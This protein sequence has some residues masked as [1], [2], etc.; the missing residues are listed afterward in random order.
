M[1]NSN[2]IKT[3]V[4]DLAEEFSKDFSTAIPFKLLPNG[5]LLYKNYLV[6]HTD[7][8]YWGIF[9]VTDQ[10]LVH[11]FF[12]KTCALLA[13]K[14]YN[15]LKFNQYFHIKNLDRR[16]QAYHN[17]IIVY[18]NNIKNITDHERHEI[19]QNKLQESQIRASSYRHQI[20]N[21]FKV[22]FCINTI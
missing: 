11:E 20:S 4:K 10:R 2:K 12:L 16:Y 15:D 21:L 5:S 3:I 9:D 7:N 8:K 18:K 19:M 22:A 14:E 17:D 13:A 6:K 1:K